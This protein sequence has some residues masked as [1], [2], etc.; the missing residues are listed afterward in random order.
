MNDSVN[1]KSV[2]HQKMLSPLYALIHI[3]SWKSGINSQLPA[4]TSIS[5]VHAR[6]YNQVASVLFVYI[7]LYKYCS[8]ILYA[9]GMSKDLSLS[10]EQRTP[11]GE[12]RISLFIYSLAKSL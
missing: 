7:G 1:E 6:L 2:E 10:S 3:P 12:Q 9:G 5:P 4:V 8:Y 11:L